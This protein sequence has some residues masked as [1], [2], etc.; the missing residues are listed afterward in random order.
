MPVTGGQKIGLIILGIVLFLVL[1]AAAF[2]VSPAPVEVF[3][4]DGTHL[5]DF[6]IGEN[7]YNI[8]QIIFGPAVD[9][10]WVTTSSFFQYLIFPFA[11]IWLVMFGIFK[12]IVFFRRVTWF[13]SVMALIVALITSS[14][15][16]LVRI[17]RG[18]LMMAGGLGIVFFGFILI[19]GLFLWFIGKVAFGFG[20][21]LGPLKGAVERQ[22]RE[23]SI[24]EVVSRGQLFAQSLPDTDPRK[25]E[26]N[27]LAATINME[28][29][30]GTEASLNEAESKAN[31]L[32]DLV[33]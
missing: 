26:I 27:V 9:K 21:G 10:T 31:K 22:R 15:G 6:Q 16:I 29:A 17:M 32:A 8:L 28:L 20:V 3:T 4:P 2:L 11:A 14:S 30:K 25:G 23:A 19:I 24:R 7:W 33:R 12:E 1:I 13:G 18:Y 5:G